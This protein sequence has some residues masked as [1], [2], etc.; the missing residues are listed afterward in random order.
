M[1]INLPNSARMLAPTYLHPGQFTRFDP[2]SDPVIASIESARHAAFT[3]AEHIVA[4]ARARAENTMDT[5]VR[6]MAAARTYARRKLAETMPKLDAA[7]ARG[8]A[9]IE[10]LE[11]VIATSLSEAALRW[12]FADA[13]RQHVRGL[14]NGAARTDFVMDSLKGDARAAGAVIGAP[15]Y[16]S[17]LS[18]AEHAMLAVAHRRGVFPAEAA[19]IDKIT[20]AVDI[21][22]RGGSLFL[23]AVHS[24]FDSAEIAAAAEKEQA[25][26]AAE[27]N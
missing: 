16:L 3:A 24:M 1:K 2:D 26:L 5:P 21:I 22:G 19:R 7:R 27:R 18:E 25:A 12:S 9:A 8:I 20:E 11:R 4:A 13:T 17:G 15:A 6:N 23:E 10:S 14:P